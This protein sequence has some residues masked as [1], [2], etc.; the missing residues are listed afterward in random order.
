MHNRLAM[1]GWS[2]HSTLAKQDYNALGVAA[3]EEG[4]YDK[5]IAYY[6]KAIEQDPENIDAYYN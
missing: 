1:L 2:I 4:N 3:Y 5:A 6:T